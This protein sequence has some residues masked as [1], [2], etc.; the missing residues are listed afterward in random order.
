MADRVSAR[1]QGSQDIAEIQTE[2]ARK[3]KELAEA[4]KRELKDTEN[5]YN[6]RIENEKDR[7]EAAVNHIRK[8]NSK[9]IRNLNQELEQYKVGL[10]ERAQAL[11]ERENE[12]QKK[13]VENSRGATNDFE[14]RRKKVDERAR[15]DYENQ[16]QSINKERAETNEKINKERAKIQ[17][18]YNRQTTETRQEREKRLA[19]EKERAKADIERTRT[20]SI[21][22][23]EQEQLRGEQIRTQVK[24]KVEAEVDQQRARGETKLERVNQENEQKI[25]QAK[26]RGQNQEQAIMKGYGKQIETNKKV[27]EERLTETQS[28]NERQLKQVE[29][30]NQNDLKTE[31]EQYDARK[32]EMSENF[33]R[34]SQQN[35][36]AYRK[37]LDRQND[38]F[39]SV[40]KK[41]Q[42]AQ[43][44]ALRIQERQFNRRLTDLKADLAQKVERY[45][46]R[47]ADPFY[48][49]QEPDSRV[50]ET[51]SSYILE[52][53]IPQHE[54]NNIKVKVQDDKAIISGTRS[55]VDK[56]DEGDRALSTN[57]YQT[58]KEEYRFE[59]PVS[60]K[61]IIQERDGDF[62]KVIIP[63]LGSLSIKG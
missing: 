18:T 17:E 19:F 35:Q 43:N 37:T 27:G 15:A 22:L 33:Q 31:Q 58:Y 32:K 53:R 44:E 4:K 21:Q 57:S 24:N 51:P 56:I 45:E 54:R 60:A 52:T 11:N 10:D 39:Q 62:L 59:K 42:N 40:Y 63:K 61:A 1:N 9:E 49:L 30:A 14:A 26:L 36:E 46:D 5:Y 28:R 34:T 13:M 6:E 55:F 25:E 12:R 23:R 16:I 50:R 29:A 47:K 2:N 7:G 41:N 20:E 38:Q 3:K 8:R 48:K